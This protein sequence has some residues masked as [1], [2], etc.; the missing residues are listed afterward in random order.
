MALYPDDKRVA[1][2][3]KDIASLKTVQIAGNFKIAQFYENNKKWAGAVVYYNE[4]LQLDP[5]SSY[6][7]PARQKIELLKP[8]LQTAMN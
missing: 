8:R 7:A 2:A 4:V 1:E 6:A 5:N 3:Q